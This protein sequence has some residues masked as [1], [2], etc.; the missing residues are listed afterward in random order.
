M[1]LWVG[2]SGYSYR[3][4]VGAFYPPGTP[5]RAMLTYYARQFP[6]T[7][8]NY[9]FYRMPGPRELERLVSKTP[10]GFQFVVKLHQSISHDNYLDAA[11][12]FR[13]AVEPLQKEGRLIALL[14]QYPQRTHYSLASLARLEELAHA[15]DGLP[16][17]V[18]F[19]HRS[20]AAPEVTEWLSRHGIRLVSV[21]V[22]DLPG[23]YPS[24]LVQTSRLL[25]V[26][27]HSHNAH[28]WYGGD[29]ERYDY[30]Y[31]DDELTA[32]L[33][34]IADR[35][36]TADRALLV[37]NN[38]MDGQAAINARRVPELV[39]RLGDKLRLAEPPAGSDPQGSLF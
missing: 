27:L 19:R 29:K 7:E 14:C 2:T 31:S 28:N 38:C 32:W 25:Y 24:G 33:Q 3:D 16:L 20:W 22:P 26:R 39:R 1:E 30:L 34:T 13:E 37:F 21:D 35:D 6:L 17:A 15:L 12:P 23:L 8:L 4:W 18:E 36:H 10:D 9:T 11:T 5:P